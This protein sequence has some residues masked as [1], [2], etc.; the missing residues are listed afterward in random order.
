MAW[1]SARTISSLTGVTRSSARTAW[2]SAETTR[3][4]AR[5]VRS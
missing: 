4:A 2:G 5:T 3:A 1:I